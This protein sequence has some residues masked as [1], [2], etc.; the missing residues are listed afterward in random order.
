MMFPVK[1][2]ENNYTHSTRNSIPA[3]TA[4]AGTIPIAALCNNRT[5]RQLHW[6]DRPLSAL[7]TAT[8]RSAMIN[9]T[10]M[11]APAAIIIAAAYFGSGQALAAPCATPLMG[12]GNHLPV[13]S[14]AALAPTGVNPTVVNLAGPSFTGTWVSPVQPAWVGTFT[15]TGQYPNS[16]GT[17]MSTWIFGGLGAGNLRVHVFRIE[18][19]R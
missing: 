10:I 18:R 11:S 19:C 5:R 7:H 8:L 2:D 17:G 12:S 14:P 16:G 15:G 4:F 3:T 13:P 9:K 6:P 1:A